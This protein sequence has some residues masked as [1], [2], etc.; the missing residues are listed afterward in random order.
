MFQGQDYFANV[1]PDLVLREF[2]T[3]IEMGEE[4]TAVDVI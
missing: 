4:F 3:L 1:D 2:L